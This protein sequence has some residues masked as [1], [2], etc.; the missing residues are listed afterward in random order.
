[1]FTLGHHHIGKYVVWVT[2]SIF[3]LKNDNPDVINLDYFMVLIHKTETIGFGKNKVNIINYV[4][5]LKSD[6]FRFIFNVDKDYRPIKDSCDM[7]QYN[8]YMDHKD[9]QMPLWKISKKNVLS[10][11]DRCQKIA[12]YAIL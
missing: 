5:L 3:S 11:L 4:N 1:M 6:D 8:H 12:T 7:V 9:M 2:A 10:L